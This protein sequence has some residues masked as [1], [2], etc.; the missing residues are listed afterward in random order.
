MQRATVILRCLGSLSIFC[1]FLYP[2]AVKAQSQCPAM[3]GYAEWAQAEA[4]K[5][6]GPGL[7]SDEGLETAKNETYLKALEECAE[8]FLPMQEKLLA[9]MLA[10]QESCE[11]AGCGY[12]YYLFLDACESSFFNIHLDNG[13]G[14]NDC[15]RGEINWLGEKPKRIFKCNKDYPTSSVLAEAVGRILYQPTCT[16]EPVAI[17]VVPKN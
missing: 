4:E 1:L 14:S 13:P 5:D 10:N 6:L 9:L 12:N 17:E 2:I 15:Q 16:V 3:Q 11:K 8:S 7:P